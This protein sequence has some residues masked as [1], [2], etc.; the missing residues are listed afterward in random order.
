MASV[1]IHLILQRNA[2]GCCLF[3]YNVNIFC[4][5]L[6][7]ENLNLA[8]LVLQGC[9]KQLFVLFVNLLIT[10]SIHQLVC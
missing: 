6:K 2:D 9:N 10:F 3:C 5:F 4:L 7:K 8:L 1:D